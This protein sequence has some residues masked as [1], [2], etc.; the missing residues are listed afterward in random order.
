MDWKDYVIEDPAF[1]RLAD[2]GLL[3]CD[4]TKAREKLWQPRIA[5]KDLVRLMV[6]ADLK[7]VKD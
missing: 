6:E 4:A 5:F 3:V 2:M 7:R 1:Y